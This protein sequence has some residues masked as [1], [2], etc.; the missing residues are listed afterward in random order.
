M[1]KAILFIVFLIGF[2]L[3]G[4][5][6]KTDP[7][8]VLEKEQLTFTF[9]GTSIEKQKINATVEDLK[10]GEEAKLIFTSKDEAVA[11]VD[12]NG[13]VTAVGV[14]ETDITITVEG[15]EN[16]KATVKVKVE[17]DLDKQFIVNVPDKI[18]AGEE[19]ELE[20]TDL[21][22]DGS[23]VFW[24]A[25]TPNIATVTPDGVVTGKA[26]GIAKF[27][28]HSAIN[29]NKVEFE[30]EV[31]LPEVEEIKIKSNLTGE[32]QKTTANLKLTVEA[33]PKYS[34][35]EVYWVSSDETV[36]DVDELG[37][38][39]VY[40]YGTV[41]FTAISAENEE[42]TDSVTFE[43]FW[44]VMDLID[45]VMVDEVVVKKQV[46][47]IGY[48]APG[49]IITDI[50]GSVSNFYFGLYQEYERIIPITMDNRP[51]IPQPSTEYI[52]VHDTASTARSADAQMH[53]NYVNNG[54]GGTSWHYSIGNDGVYRQ[55]PLDEISYHAGDGSREFELLDTG[56]K[57]K[58]KVKPIVAIDATGYYTLNGEKTLIAAPRGSNGEILKTSQINDYGV[59]LE[60]G[61]N[62]NWW[63][64][65]TYY[66]A[67]YKLI[68]NHGGN[69]NSIGIETMVNE[70]SDLYLTWQYTAKKVAELLLM[71]DLNLDRVKF[72]HFFSG[73][74]CP[75]TMRTNGMVDQFLKMVEAE[76][77][78][79][80]FFGDYQITMISSHPDIVDNSGKVVKL[81]TEATDVTL[82]VSVQ[83]E[84]GFNQTKAYRYTIQ[85]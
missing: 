9:E 8:L 40:T 17:V 72:H 50:I 57:A 71:F 83:N 37:N 58:S 67:T 59:T 85:P 38:V 25:V 49:Y 1:K 33:T 78:I 46:K 69:R 35:Q 62:G 21:L 6:T 43:F 2:A 7:K 27:E 19:V 16:L 70:G 15:Y 13:N 5:T 54:G 34:Y 3:I 36:A 60:I 51:G 80:K 18:V 61:E 29:A 66:N 45:Y 4:C 41:T 23:G 44:D 12:A 53:A 24:V 77:L 31:V 22:D 26:K 42:I 39:T 30:I 32:L 10:D 20:V 63:M 56:V 73:K 82:L 68:S 28:V 14:G 11:T 47:A 74:D 55:L 48:Q 64:N 75:Q 81:P 52:T 65:K 79:Q 76:Y 84:A